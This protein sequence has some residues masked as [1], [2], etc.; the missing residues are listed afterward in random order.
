MKKP[1]ANPGGPGDV[2]WVVEYLTELINMNFDAI[3]SQDS[4]GGGNENSASDHVVGR[5]TD[6][7]F[8]AWHPYVSA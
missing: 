5:E 4:V 3:T 1:N 6:G 2:I 8:V 7:L